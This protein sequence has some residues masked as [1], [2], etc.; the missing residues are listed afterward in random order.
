M[1]TAYHGDN[2]MWQVSQLKYRK[3]QRLLHGMVENSSLADLYAH[4][5]IHQLF[6]SSSGLGNNICQITHIL[7][8][9]QLCACSMG[10]CEGQSL[11]DAGIDYEVDGAS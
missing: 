10:C 8:G 1:R 4:L 6:G 9:L 11:P 2:A 5:L 3:K 7:A